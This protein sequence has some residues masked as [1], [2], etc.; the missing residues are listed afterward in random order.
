MLLS[1]FATNASIEILTY[2]IIGG[3]G[4][5]LLYVPACVAPSFWFSKTRALATGNVIHRIHFFTS[6]ILQGIATCGSGFGAFA[7][8]P[9]ISF[10]KGRFGWKGVMNVLGSLCFS[11]IFFGAVMSK[12]RSL[13]N[14]D[15][16]HDDKIN[17]KPMKSLKKIL[18]N[19]S[20][21]MLILANPPAVMGHYLL[22]VFLPEV[23]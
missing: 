19:R 13:E 1:T 22:Y 12:P 2:G 10:V 21:L 17:E 16:K 18:K 8:A 4:L 5:G 3:L 23:G 6:V 20:L 11:C 14:E 15:D 9:L 7:L